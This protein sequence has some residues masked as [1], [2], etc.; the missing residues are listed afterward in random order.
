MHVV[1]PVMYALLLANLVN[2][3]PTGSC[4]YGHLGFRR[5]ACWVRVRDGAGSCDPRAGVFS[6]AVIVRRE[7]ARPSGFT[8]SHLSWDLD[9]RNWQDR[10][11][12]ACRP[13]P[14]SCWRS[15]SSRRVGAGWRALPGRRV[16]AHQIVLNIIS[17]IF[18]APLGF[19]TAAAVRV[20]HAIGRGI[21]WA[22][23][24]PA[25]RRWP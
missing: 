16:A 15:A 14:D 11:A 25:G 13:R 1:R 12:A 17:F 6:F 7:R 8:T 21:R 18:M 9:E 19:S 23:G 4:I 2:L 20:G 3:G 5:W 24:Q 22:H 10:A